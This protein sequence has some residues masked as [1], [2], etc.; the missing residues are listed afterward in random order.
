MTQFPAELRYSDAHLWV[1]QEGELVILGITTHAVEQLGEITGVSLPS[2][3]ASL[4]LSD[5]FGTVESVKASSD[6]PSPIAGTVARVNDALDDEPEKIEDDPY[7]DGWLIAVKREGGASLEGLMT[8]SDYE[9]KIAH[10]D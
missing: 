5:H 4:A 8:A 10:G 3:G 9:K 6:L 7:G 1:R 2:V